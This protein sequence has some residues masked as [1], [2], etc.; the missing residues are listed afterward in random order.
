[1]KEL[2]YSEV[3]QSRTPGDKLRV[4]DKLEELELFVSRA[5]LFQ[6]IAQLFGTQ[7][8]LFFLRAWGGGGRVSMSLTES[9]CFI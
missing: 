7:K 9:I 2:P 6:K 3:T 4:G 1:M 5:H 8:N